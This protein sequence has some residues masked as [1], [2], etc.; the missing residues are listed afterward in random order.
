MSLFVRDP[1]KRARREL[2]ELERDMYDNQRA[3]HQVSCNI[4]YIQARMQY[5]RT[6]LNGTIVP[7]QKENVR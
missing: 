1:A 3:L 4:A 5:L 7:I 6:M 2:A